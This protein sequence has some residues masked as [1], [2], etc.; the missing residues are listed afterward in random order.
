M[1]ELKLTNI[2]QVFKEIRISRGL[3]LKELCD[4]DISISSLSNF[5][6]GKTDISFTKFMKLIEKVNISYDEFMYMIKNDRVMQQKQFF[7][8]LRK[9]V[10]ESDQEKILLLSK[11]E[12][13]KFKETNLDFHLVNTSL[14]EL[15]YNRMNNMKINSNLVK[16]ISDYLLKQDHWFYYDVALINNSMF[17][18]PYDDMVGLSKLVSKKLSWYIDMSEKHNEIVLLYINLSIYM[19]EKGDRNKSK[20]LIKTVVDYIKDTDWLYEINKIRFIQGMW[21]IRVGEVSVGEML[22]QSSINTFKQ[23]K[24][25]KIAASHKVY[26]ENFISKYK[27]KCDDR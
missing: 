13:K 23:L 24:K 15:H 6:R 10:S 14:V 12:K 27:K 25:E 20:R 16:I 5:E 17:C 4:N 3:G 22:C 8:N 21:E 11:K 7:K 9:Y 26:L 1:F 19:I 2:G 18:V